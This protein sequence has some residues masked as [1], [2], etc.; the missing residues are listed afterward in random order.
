MVSFREQISLYCLAQV[1][2]YGMDSLELLKAGS[3]NPA[4]CHPPHKIP[5]RGPLLSHKPQ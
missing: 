2:R 5:P 3:V 4:H 1:H